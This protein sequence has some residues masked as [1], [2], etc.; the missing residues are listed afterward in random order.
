MLL[1][2]KYITLA[3][4]L[5]SSIAL[6][7]Q[8]PTTGGGLQTPGQ[9]SEKD[10]DVTLNETERI[11]TDLTLPALDTSV[12]AQKYDL[13]TRNFKVDYAA[14]K[15]RP[16]GM[17]SDKK[18]KNEKGKNG[19]VKLGYGI[20]HSPY[21]EAGYSYS[22]SNLD[23]TIAVKHHSMNNKN[24]AL[25]KFSE[26]GGKFNLGYH[27]N[28]N[29][30]VGFKLGYDQNKYGAFGAVDSSLATQAIASEAYMTP[31]YNKFNLGF[32]FYNT[33]RN[34]MDLTYGASIDFSHLKDNQAS[35]ENNTDIK[36]HATKWFA[37]KHPLTIAIR[38]DFNKF[39]F[40]GATRKE[41]LNNI[42][43][44]PSFTFHADAFSLKA[45]MNLV[46]NNDEWA[47]LPDLEATVRVLGDRLA[48]FGGWKG[49]V[50]KNTFHTLTAYNP[51]VLS[52]LQPN[53]NTF[54][55]MQNSRFQDYFGGVKGIMNGI[56]Y[57]VQ[58][59]YK[60]TTS[61]AFF[62]QNTN[63]KY[64]GKNA[65]FDNGRFDVIY[66][67][68]NITYVKGSLSTK[69]K[70]FELAATLG[71][72]IY[73]MKGDSTLTK[74]W[75]LPSTEF[76]GLVAYRFLQ[77]KMKVKGQVFFQNPIPFRHPTGGTGATASM[78]DLSLGAEYNINSNFGLFLN[79]NNLLNQKRA[80]WFNYPSY[81]VN[82]LGGLVARF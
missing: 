64:D 78:F 19:F 69:I 22:N 46:S 17:G 9:S 56:N 27:L 29:Y 21:G 58:A 39:N 77:D 82:V 13:S 59:G 32:N 34:D 67:D 12:K 24:V 75:H 63:F 3:I 10:F 60:P 41:T 1:T 47:V 57:N 18:D 14:P 71:Q 37:E 38:T 54:K 45:G 16:I 49:D 31:K 43:L 7:A 80:R 66:G 11:K 76:N 42:Y 70:G 4:L 55:R 52:E 44:T 61:L 74:P 79:V 81:G 72:N 53:L 68:A 15:I 5:S 50:Q 35:K 28:K 65:N 6:F 73:S 2:K 36:L 40:S 33:E 8:K 20:P 25:Q 23:A 62:T 48:I 30:A 51:Y 26:T